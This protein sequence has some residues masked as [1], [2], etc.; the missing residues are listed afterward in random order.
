MAHEKNPRIWVIVP[1]AGVGSRMR[2]ELPKQYLPLLDS[3]LIEITLRKLLELPGVAGVVVALNEQDR[4]WQTTS[5]ASHPGIHRVSG[6]RE[7]SDSVVNG[8]QY[9]LSM[10]PADEGADVWALVHD[11]ARPCVSLDRIVE[12]IR[13]AL[14]HKDT[15]AGAILASP[16]SDTIKRVHRN[17]ISATE[18][19]ATLWLAHTPQFFPLRLLRDAIIAA[20][21]AGAVITDEASAVEAVGGAVR[22]VVDRRDNIKVTVPE[23]LLCAA[24]ILR[25]QGVT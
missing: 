1:A 14:R 19:R 11:A 3:T 5:I 16:C 8:L 20:R 6:G 23:D 4:H 13:L 10:A 17:S 18:D 7:R 24:T 25:Q 22:V 15:S 12:L 9:C 21:E 2:S